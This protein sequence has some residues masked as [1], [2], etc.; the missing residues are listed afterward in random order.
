MKK[1][2]YLS[3]SFLFCAWNKE[4][5]ENEAEKLRE[6]KKNFRKKIFFL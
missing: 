3:K 4:R 1:T 5:L 6:K 2:R